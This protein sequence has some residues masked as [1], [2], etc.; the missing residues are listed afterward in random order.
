MRKGYRGW[1][2]LEELQFDRPL[3]EKE[4]ASFTVY[5]LQD[6]LS[7]VFARQLEKRQSF[8]RIRVHHVEGT[9]AISKLRF[10]KVQ[11]ARWSV[12]ATHFETTEKI[13][14]RAASW[15]YE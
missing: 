5:R 14:F 9:E 12:D 7:R 13:T 11:V 4:A 1:L 10:D 6:A 8:S 15:R 2:A 3:L